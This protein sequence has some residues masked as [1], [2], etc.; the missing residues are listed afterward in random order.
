MSL[1]EIKILTFALLSSL[2][3]L[4]GL[5]QA[6]REFHLLPRTSE[7]KISCRRFCGRSRWAGCR[8][9]LAISWAGD[10]H[11]AWTRADVGP[12]RRFLPAVLSRL[13]CTKSI[14]IALWSSRCSWR[15]DW[16]G[17]WWRWWRISLVIIK[18]IA[19]A[20]GPSSCVGAKGA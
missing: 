10:A 16:L 9:T 6:K 1:F 18:T 4:I 19:R 13:T 2:L 7:V 5:L 15:S 8:I 3:L 12:V 17:G 14:T 11:R 20:F